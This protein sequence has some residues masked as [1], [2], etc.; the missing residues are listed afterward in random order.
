MNRRFF[1]KLAS[2][3]A[4]APIFLPPFARSD[5]AGQAVNLVS[6]DKQLSDAWLKALTARGEPEI[7][8][9]DELKYIGMPVGGLCAG[10]VYIGGDG[11]L[12]L[13][14]VFNRDTMQKRA[15]YEGKTLNNSTGSLYVE[16]LAQ[17]SPLAQGFALKYQAGVD[18][19]QRTLD[20]DGG[21]AEMTFQGSYPLATVNYRDPVVPITVKLDAFSP[22]IPLNVADSSLPATIMRYTVTNMGRALARVEIASWMEN[23][24]LHKSTPVQEAT[25]LNRE[26]KDAH[27]QGILLTSQAQESAA[28][29]PQKNALPV[30]QRNDYG[31]MVLAAIEPGNNV[32]TRM[33]LPPGKPEE[34]AFASQEAEKPDDCPVGAVKKAIILAPGESAAFDFVLAWHFPNIDPAM[35]AGKNDIHHY[36]TRFEDAA[37]VAKYVAENFVRL[38]SDTLT[39]CETWND[40]TLPYWFLNRTFSNTCNLATTT[41]YRFADGQ[42]WA[43]EGIYS[44]EGTCTHVWAYAQ[45]MARIFPELERTLREKTD[46]TFAFN[47]KDGVIN[48]R[49]THAGFA[50]DGQAGI[51]LRTYREHQMSADDSFLRPLWPKVSLALNRLIQQVNAKGLLDG[52][53]NNTLDTAWFGEIA[54]ISGL[55]LAALRAGEEMA[56]AMGDSSYAQ[57]CRQLF[58]QGSQ[59]LV[60][61]LFNGEYFINKVDPNHLA[62]INSGL[63]SEIDQLFGQSWAWQVGLGRIFPRPETVSALKSLWRYNF[64]PD[65]GKYHQDMKMGRWYALPGEAGLLMCTFPK[66]G[67]DFQQAAG[68]GPEFAVGYFNECMTGFEHQVASHLIAEGLVQEGLAVTRAIHDRYAPLKRNPYN[69]I[70]CGDHYS[71]AMASYG[72]F[73]TICGFE[74]RG[75]EGYLAFAPRLSP[76]NFKAAFTSAEG[77]GTYFQAQENAG[78]KATVVVKWGRLQLGTLSFVPKQSPRQVI[79]TLNGRP[80]QASGSFTN[81]QFVVTFPQ[82]VSLQAND[83]L[84]ISCS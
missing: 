79:A 15:T 63:G 23:I 44:C 18:S 72:S 47:P 57:K 48:F 12:W 27:H 58:E 35:Q 51:I 84:E 68:K 20:K 9:G 66:P 16:P 3:A 70:E 41:S 43:W 33:A 36:A 60:P 22:F 46:Y 42:F 45:A 29:P 59:S 49:G 37:A 24:V 50:A 77:W 14:D 52:P 13:W 31:T 38:S 8:R 10:L 81:G 40:S 25:R 5:E 61:E 26:I 55:Y 54:W 39:W 34:L 82:R 69:E 73:I 62:A 53:Q 2:G 80:M 28:P 75:P 19:G 65:A 30:S 6:A 67:W 71:R 7:L 78:M 76:E 1:L 64:T 74:Y 83:R 11:K 21:W 56:R 17:R 32:S 4:V